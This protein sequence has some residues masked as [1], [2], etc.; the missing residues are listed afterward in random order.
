MSDQKIRVGKILFDTSEDSLTIESGVLK[1][2]GIEF[3]SGSGGITGVDAADVT[4]TPETPGN[5]VSVPDDVSQ[6]LDLLSVPTSGSS[7]SASQ[8]FFDDTGMCIV[9]SNV[10]EAIDELE[11]KL[12]IDI[13]NIDTSLTSYVAEYV[14]TNVA[15][16]AR[17]I[18]FGNSAGDGVTTTSS[19]TVDTSATSSGTPIYTNVNLDGNL[20]ITNGSASVS[21]GNLTVYDG[22]IR[23]S[24]SYGA[25]V[26]QVAGSSLTPNANNGAIFEFTMTSD[27]SSINTP[28][29]MD[30]GEC[31][32]IIL[33]QDGS[34]DRV[35]SFAGTYLFPGGTPTFSTA[36]G[37]IDVVSVIRVNAGYLATAATNFS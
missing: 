20:Y 35:P 34:G 32:N 8:V 27:S 4:Y 2:N 3:E 29:N 28:T 15:G 37:A 16:D 31:L 24:G 19:L 11:T 5:W 33:I 17:E 23:S 30:V 25:T 21:G 26:I 7:I 1:V 18:I 36:S 12:Q 6:A 13:A 14:S 10:N 22:S 9:A